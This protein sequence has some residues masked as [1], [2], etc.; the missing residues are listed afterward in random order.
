M[1]NKIL[2]G[3]SILM[4]LALTLSCSARNE[5]AYMYDTAAPYLSDYR[6]DKADYGGGMYQSTPTGG[7]GASAGAID[8]HDKIIKTYSFYI[9]AVNY[10]E[11]YTRVLSIID[12]NSG[13]V[14]NSYVSGQVISDYTTYRVSP[15]ENIYNNMRAASFTIRIPKQ[16]IDTFLKDIESCGNLISRSEMAQD[17]TFSYS[18]MESRTASLYA[19]QERLLELMKEAKNVE[20]IMLIEARLA[21]VMYEIE[22]YEK[23]LLSYD[24]Q[25]EYTTV[26]VNLN[27]VSKYSNAIPE[28]ATLGER[29]SS[30]F[31]NSIENIKYRT[32]NLIVWV[33]SNVIYWVILAVVIIVFVII[34]KKR[35]NKKNKTKNS[36]INNI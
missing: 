12:K 31:K 22:S 2:L 4:V 1:K 9:E 8:V 25:I 35:K 18:D 20:E 21:E 24:D 17:V 16:N 30:G 29:I 28:N 5:E 7:P 10:D 36:D 32:T 15:K 6:Y 11:S 19:Q 13:F 33:L 3:L 14:E 26:N 27:E 34:G 23:Q